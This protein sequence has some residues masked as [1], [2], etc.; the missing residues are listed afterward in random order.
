ME[1]KALSKITNTLIPYN[2]EN[3]METGKLPNVPN[4]IGEKDGSFYE[5]M[6]SSETPTA[7]WQLHQ[8]TGYDSA[9]YRQIFGVSA[10]NYG[11]G[12]IRQLFRIS[13]DKFAPETGY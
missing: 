11:F 8:A 9:Q 12:D 2:V 10:D 5:Y 13:R 7:V 3:A 4:F 6:E 1:K